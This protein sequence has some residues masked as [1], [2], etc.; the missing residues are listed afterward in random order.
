MCCPDV[1]T[2]L[3]STVANSKRNVK[4]RFVNVLKNRGKKM[5]FRF[6]VLIIPPEDVVKIND[7]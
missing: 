1:A 5:S 2:M 6:F 7:E 4:G 3:A